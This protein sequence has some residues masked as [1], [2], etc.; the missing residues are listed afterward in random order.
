MTIG[1]CA[2]RW[3]ANYRAFDAVGTLQG[4]DEIQDANNP[5]PANPWDPPIVAGNTRQKY[6]SIG[7]KEY[8]VVRT[9]AG[10]WLNYTRA[11]ADQKLLCLSAREQL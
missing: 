1:E 6:A 11:F 10:E 2:R 4:T 5:P 9:E 3:F 7:M 8:E